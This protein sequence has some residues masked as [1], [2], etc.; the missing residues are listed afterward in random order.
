M[1]KNIV[2]CKKCG[3]TTENQFELVTLK[4]MVDRGWRKNK[5]YQAMGDILHEA[6]CDDCIDE[7]IKK[8]ASQTKKIVNLSVR[9]A[10][11]VVGCVLL[12]LFV[13]LTAFR[14][15]CAIIGVIAILAFLQEFSNIKKDAKSSAVASDNRKNLAVNLLSTLLPKKHNDAELTYIDSY[16]IKKG[17]LEQLGKEYGISQKKLAQIRS[18]LKEQKSNQNL[19]DE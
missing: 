17:N 7:Y 5:Y 18:F 3:A 16:L 19:L 8:I 4:T 9:T 1:E 14:V 10:V 13:S 12:F 6:V 2:N 11:V 15:F